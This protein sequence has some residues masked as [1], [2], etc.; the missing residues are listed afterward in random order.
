MLVRS[1]CAGCHTV[2]G[3]PAVGTRGPDLTHLASRRTIGAVTLE[4]TRANL[5]RWVAD[6]ST[7]KPG[8]LMPPALLSPADLAAVLAYLESRS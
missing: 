4:N 6:A 1:S 8:V 5:S 3:T 7:A 2:R